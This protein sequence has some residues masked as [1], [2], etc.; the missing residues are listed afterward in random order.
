MHAKFL[1]VDLFVVSCTVKFKLLEKIVFRVSIYLFAM[2][3]SLLSKFEF[4]LKR[5]IVAEAQQIA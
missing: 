5:G 2:E 1:L 4:T 3:Y